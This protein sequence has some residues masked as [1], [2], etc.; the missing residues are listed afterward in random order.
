MVQPITVTLIYKGTPTPT[1]PGG[2]GSNGG[3]SGGSGVISVIQNQIVPTTYIDQ[4]KTINAIINSNEIVWIYDP[5]V[6]TFKMNITTNGQTVPANS[7]FYLIN[8]VVEQNINSTIINNIST[9]T[10]YFDKYGNMLTGWIKTNPD[11]K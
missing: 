7:G 9:N 2:G 4:I 10:Y 8:N 6:D 5:I 3:G 11:N 1:P